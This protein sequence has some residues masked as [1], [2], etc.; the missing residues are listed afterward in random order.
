M[1]FQKEEW[2]VEFFKQA[3]CHVPVKDYLET[4]DEKYQA[5]IIAYIELLRAHGGRLHEPYAKQIKGS[6]WELRV[7]FGR[8]ASRMFYFLSV[9][10][11]IVLLHA[12]MKKTA[13]T[14]LREIEKAEQYYHEYL[15]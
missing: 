9:G 7:D 4:L 13:K 1:P 5:K 3:N 12:F 2:R 14:P 15:Q 6:I 10:K 8:L 11:R